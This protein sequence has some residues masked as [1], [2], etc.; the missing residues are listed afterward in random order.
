MSTQVEEFLRKIE[1]GQEVLEAMKRERPTRP[2]ETEAARK[3]R[4]EG[5]LMRLEREGIVRRG[6]GKLPGNFWNLPRP[7]DPGN[8]V[9]RALEEDR[10]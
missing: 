5:S 4:E 6:S 10:R 8:S 3:I 2:S 9:R 1:G 7:E